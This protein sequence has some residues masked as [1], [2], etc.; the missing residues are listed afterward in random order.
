MSNGCE[1]LGLRERKRIATRRA[2]ELAVLK[3]TAERGFDRVTIDDI[4]HAAEI[5]PRTFFNYF[6]TKDEALVGDI[7]T[8]PDGVAVEKFV[9]AGP[10]SSIL[11]G[12]GELFAASVDKTNDDREIY[13]LRKAVMKEHPHLIG[14]RIATMRRFEETVQE[15]VERRLSRDHAAFDSDAEQ[16][17]DRALLVTLVAF[18]GLRHAWQRWT[19]ADDSIPLSDRVRAS[20]RDL[21]EVIN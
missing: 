18:S 17:A 13:L 5:S 16:L 11:G 6:A 10:H 3:L 9:A 4:G 8:L 12:L 19:E 1:G 7:P 21:I 15:I 14:L 2:I 20:F